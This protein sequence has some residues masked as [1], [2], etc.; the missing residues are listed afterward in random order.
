VFFPVLLRRQV[1]LGMARVWSPLAPVMTMQ[2]VVGGGQRDLAPPA[3]IQRWLDL[4][5]Y[6]DTAGLGRR[7]ERR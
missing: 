4:A 6:Q 7:E 1:G 5:H 3:A 2:P